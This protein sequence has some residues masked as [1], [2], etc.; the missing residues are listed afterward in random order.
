MSDINY[1][2]INENFPVPGQ[3][4]DTQVFRDNFDTIKTSLGTAQS[5]IT[6]L[7]NSASRLNVDNN[8]QDNVQQNM[9]L[10]EAKEKVAE[11]ATI[12][13]SQHQIDFEN[14]SYQIVRYGVSCD[15]SFLNLPD[16]QAQ[17][18]GV[19]RIM[20][21]LYGTG[22]ESPVTLSFVSTGGL[23]FKKSA[24]FP[25]SLTVQSATDPTFVEIWQH[26]AD[27]IF[28]KYHGQYA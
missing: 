18:D 15:I 13:N 7:E 5:E 23:V 16:A 19:G 17:P 1:L 14:G 26:S 12:E 6:T 11:L 10:L 21:E 22:T 24:D 9:I 25:S 4:N 28:L 8:Y 20:L 2:S 27:K 3:D